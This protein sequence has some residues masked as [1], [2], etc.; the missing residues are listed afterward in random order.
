MLRRAESTRPPRRAV[1]SAR[2]FSSY[3]VDAINTIDLTIDD[4]PPLVYI[5]RRH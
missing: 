2:A 5:R 1:I 3:H 4:L